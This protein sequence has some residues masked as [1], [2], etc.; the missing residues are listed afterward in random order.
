[1]SI[2][3][4]LFELPG[5]K[6]GNYFYMHTNGSA[7]TIPVTDDGKILLVKQYR[8]LTDNASIEIPCGGIK[9]GQNDTDA[10]RA[11]LIEE[12]G[13]DCRKLKKVGKFVSYNGLSDEY[14]TVF[15]A[16]LLHRVGAKPDETEQIEVMSAT[17]EEINTWIRK[18]KIVDGMSI[19]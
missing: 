19:A 16:K 1:M 9:D 7:M 8:Y 2:Y 12:T 17:P 11:E 5:G 18:G 4:N 10:A 13:Y 3:H 14:C 15:V 6:R